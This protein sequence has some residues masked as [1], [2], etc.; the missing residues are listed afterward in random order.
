MKIDY[1]P[2]PTV[3]VKTLQ[4][5]G[6]DADFVS[7]DI[8]E[9]AKPTAALSLGV[10]AYAWITDNQPMKKVALGV[11]VAAFLVQTLMAPKR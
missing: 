3:G 8:H 6:D 2:G 1:G 10:W 4:F 5:V 9:L 11:S 7:S